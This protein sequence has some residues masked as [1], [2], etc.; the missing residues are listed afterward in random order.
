MILF[1]SPSSSSYCFPPLFAFLLLSFQAS[2]THEISTLLVVPYL[3]ETGR[4]VHKVR[5]LLQLDLLVLG[6]RG[7]IHV[8]QLQATKGGVKGVTPVFQIRIKI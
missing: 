5:A 4:G 7:E 3:L 1:L 8:L 2:S 6:L